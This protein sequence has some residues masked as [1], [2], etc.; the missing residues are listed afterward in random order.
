M[1]RDFTAAENLWPVDPA[2]GML[3]GGQ[4]RVAVGRA[5]T[6]GPGRDGIAASHIDFAAFSADADGD[7][8]VTAGDL[9]LILGGFGL[10]GAD[11]GLFG[12]GDL[13]GDGATDADDVALALGL[14]ADDLN[15]DL[16]GV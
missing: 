16:T 12:D 7:G 3:P 11:A 9:A 4:W 8:V 14:Y 2:A 10:A 6:G 13:D 5:D 1:L 15:L